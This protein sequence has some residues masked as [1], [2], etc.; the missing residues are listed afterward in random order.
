MKRL[1]RVPAVVAVFMLA[2]VACSGGETTSTSPTA[3]TSNL[4]RGG[5]LLVETN[6]DIATSGFDPAKEYWQLSFQI[7]RCCLLRTLMTYNGLDINHGG[8]EIRPDLAAAPPTVSDDGLT[9]TFKIKSGIHYSPPLQNV[10]VTADDFVRA[11]EREADPD[12]AGAYSFYYTDIAGFS[13]YQA[14]KAKTVSGATAVDAHTLQIKLSQPA[15]DLAYRMALAAMAPIPPKPGDPSAK[16]GIADGHTDDYGQFVIGTGPYMI[17][18]AGDVDFSQPASKQKP[19]SGYQPGKHIS[20]VR[21]P[22]WDGSTDPN[23]P[24]Y[25]DGIDI[26]ISLAA[27]QGVLDKKVQA[28]EIDVTMANAPEPQSIRTFETD[29]NLKNQIFTNPA[30]SNYYITMNLATPPF[31]DIHV[32]KAVEYAIDKA[33]YV[34]LVGGPTIAG[35]VAG[36]FVPDVD[37]NNLLQGKDYYPTPENKG[38]D[39]PQGLELA[40]NE[41]KQSKYDT[42]QDGMCDASACKNVLSVGV[43]GNT[44]EAYAQLFKGNLAKIGIELDQRD[45]ENTAAYNKVF[46]PKNHI[47]FTS[48]WA[49]WIHDY[50]DGYTWF[51]PIMY[52]PNILAQY[53]TNYSMVGASSEQLKK[54]GYDVTSVPGINDQI[55]KCFPLT[56]DARTQCWAAADTAL[57]QDVAPVVPLVFSNVTN[58]VSSRVLNFQYS[59]SD[60]A[61]SWNYLALANGGS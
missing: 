59:V 42:N 11:I 44:S 29:P 18:G 14:G 56:G 26:T 12:V 30:P 6:A 28:G 34:R 57:M 25:L 41:M 36:H 10:E 61:P 60:Q 31:D 23:R 2:A 49:G 13:D 35:T 48:G 8:A 20:L 38:A 1:L 7:F 40:K 37:E 4:P 43:V 19:I 27:E 46:D 47:P 3:Q 50:P 51:Y 21:N 45:F 17:D 58:I 5:T 15:G 22:S 16:Y 32:R 55:E 33:G 9:W 52:G 24:S 54:Y 39:T 53:N